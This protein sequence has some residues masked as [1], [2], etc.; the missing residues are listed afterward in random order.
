MALEKPALG[1]LAVIELGEGHLG[2]SI[3]ERLLVNPSHAFDAAD[4]LNDRV[5]PV[6]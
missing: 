5:L 2:V 6:L 3:E 4:L 1:R